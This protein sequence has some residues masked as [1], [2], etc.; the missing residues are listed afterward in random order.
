MLSFVPPQWYKQCRLIWDGTIVINIVVTIDTPYWPLYVT[1]DSLTI[2]FP[3]PML[4]LL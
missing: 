2:F 3:F 1:F 4:V